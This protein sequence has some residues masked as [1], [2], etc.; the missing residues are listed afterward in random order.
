[1]TFNTNAGI[2]YLIVGLM[3][4]VVLAQSFF[5]FSK[6]WK[7]GL[8]IGISKDKLLRIVKSTIVFTIAPAVAIVISVI[9]L[10]KAL[11]IPLPWL[12]LSVIGNLSYETIAASNALSSMG[13]V[14]GKVSSLTASEYITISAVMTVSIMIGIWLVPVFGEKILNG[15]SNIEKRDK[16]WGE[17]LQSSLFLGMISA[18][19]GYVFSDFSTVFKGDFSGMIPV[20]VFIVSSLVMA[21]CGVIY[22][23][24]PTW[25]WIQ[26]Y[27]LPLSLIIGMISAIPFTSLL[28]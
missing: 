22:K 28:T 12:R 17:V 21:I 1:M 18:F 16:K 2:L 20:L 26:D 3:I 5:F 23:K 11:G 7:R 8:K 27:A 19:I 14:L 24:K 25:H 6:A 4:S 9:T 13:L 15:V 10:A